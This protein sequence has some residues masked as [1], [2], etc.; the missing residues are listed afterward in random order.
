MN[1]PV[2]PATYREVVPQQREPSDKQRLVL[3]VGTCEQELP[4]EGS[5][6]SVQDSVRSSET[7]INPLEL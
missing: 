4:A 6:V 7:G 2:P 3:L 5:L 1:Q